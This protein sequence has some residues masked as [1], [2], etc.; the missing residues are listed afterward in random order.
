MPGPEIVEPEA[1]FVLVHANP[2]DYTTNLALDMH[3]DPR[4]EE[5]YSEQETHAMQQLRAE[6]AR[7]PRNRT[8]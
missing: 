5:R 7:A 2:D 8:G 6:T 1:T 4:S 3:A